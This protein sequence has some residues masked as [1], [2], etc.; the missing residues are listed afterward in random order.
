MS[1]RSLQRQV[2]WQPV[3]AAARSLKERDEASLTAWF[4]KN[5]QPWQLV[6]PDASREGLITGYYE[7]VLKASR[8][9]KSLTC[10]PSKPCRM[11]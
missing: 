4:E 6:N 1:C 9:R 5:L 2:L 8:Q 3:C 7:P 11:I 10:I